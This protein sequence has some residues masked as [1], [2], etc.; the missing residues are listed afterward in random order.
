MPINNQVLYLFFLESLVPSAPPTNPFAFMDFNTVSLSWGPLP[1]KGINGELMGYAVLI[2][3]YKK[4]V[5]TGPCYLSL[6]I[7][8]LNFTSDICI[9][10]AAL[11]KVGLGKLT[12]CVPVTTGESLKVVP[13]FLHK[14]YRCG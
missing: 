3:A 2:E 12:D 9:Q 10:M 7:E 13:S 5:Y 4:Y 6:K 14:L 11:T 8:N 1:P